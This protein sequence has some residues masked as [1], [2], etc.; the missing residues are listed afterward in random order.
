DVRENTGVK[1]IKEL[2]DGAVRI[3]AGDEDFIGKY[4]VDCSGQATV[5]GRHLGTR[6]QRP[7]QHLQRI[8]YFQHFSNV[9]RL[10]G[11]EE[12]HACIVMSDEGWFWMI[13]L[14]ATRTSIGLV[15]D[16]DI[17]RSLDVPS[18]KFLQCGIEL[19]PFIRHRM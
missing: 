13:R 5:V 14:N 11:R 8:A 19:C 10:P 18:D 2:R 9:E 15:M 3:V 4:F 7:E 12:G 6:K 17:A 1:E 16:V